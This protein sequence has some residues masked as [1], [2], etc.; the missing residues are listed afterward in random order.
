MRFKSTASLMLGMPDMGD[1]GNRNA[2][3]QTQ[4]KKKKKFGI[5][6]VLKGAVGIPGS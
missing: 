2:P 1:A 4:P 3:Q 5:G 6:D